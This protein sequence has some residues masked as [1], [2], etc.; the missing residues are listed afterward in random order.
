MIDPEQAWQCVLEHV[1][2]L[3]GDNRP[4][5]DLLHFVL[6]DAVCADRDMPASDR[7]AMDG[8]A[9]RAAEAGTIPVILRAVGEVPAGSPIQPRLM[10][11]ECVRIFTGANVPTDA[12]TVVMV[13]DTETVAS[14]SHDDQVRFLKPIRHGQHIFRRGENAIRGDVLIP[15]GTRLSA[16]H[17][18]LCATAGCDRP[19]VHQMPRV[20][21]VT[22]GAELRDAGEHVGDHEIRDSNGPM[23]AAVLAQHHFP[24]VG[25]RSAP[26]DVALLVR[27]MNQALDESDVV[28]T[29]GGVSVGK[30]DLVPDAVCNAGG[31]IIYHGVQIK[32]GKP[33]LF[34]AFPS[35][36][37]IFGLPGN[38][39][40][41]MTGMHEFALPA[42]RRLAGVPAD[43]CRPML[44]LPVTADVHTKGKRRR[45]VLG[46]L[47]LQETGSHVEPVPSVGSADLAA[48]GKADGTIIVPPD[49]QHITQSEI[50]DFRPW[51]ETS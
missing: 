38:P 8:Y 35:G 4:L 20:S 24:C 37:C 50:V 31:K 22:T 27:A 26:D 45:H 7:A 23:L 5:L 32:P 36:K 33:Q 43:Q 21:I 29:T 44:R 39:L 1:A 14:S 28:L 16:V 40:S 18:S 19:L 41:A 48:A 3:P 17:I 10:P 49:R 51:G 42:L 13:E 30:Y 47:V 12:D 11:G 34:A 15:A 25:R 2:P 46:R 6:A 9:I